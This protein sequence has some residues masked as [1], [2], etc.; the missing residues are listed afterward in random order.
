[1]RKDVP[2]PGE[3]ATLG[4]H[5]GIGSLVCIVAGYPS[6]AAA[7]QAERR[8][9]QICATNGVEALDGALIEWLKDAEPAWRPLQNVARFR[10]LPANAWVAWLDWVTSS[11]T[12]AADYDAGLAASIRRGRTALVICAPSQDAVIL[13]P[14][15]TR[16][17][18]R[19]S[20]VIVDESRYLE[21]RRRGSEDGAAEETGSVRS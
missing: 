17:A 12:V 18:E 16:D 15:L 10:A 21:I 1:M 4:E 20:T 3:D 7:Q 6:T 8:V 9:G 11:A 14:E 2:H 19:V 13:V 5:D